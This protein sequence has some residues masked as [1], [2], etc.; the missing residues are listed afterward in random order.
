M[1][2]RVLQGVVISDKSDKTVVVKLS[3]V[4]LI[5]FLRRLFG[6]LKIIKRM[7]KTTNSRL[8]IR[9]L[10]RNLDQFQKINVGLL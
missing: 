5:R 1:P 4:I 8:E 9:F 10:F 7:T 2:K 6:S 3:V